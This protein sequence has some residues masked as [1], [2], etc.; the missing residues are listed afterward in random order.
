MME[1]NL[2]YV[3]TKPVMNYVL[4]VLTQFNAGAQ[5]VVIKARGKS[6]TRAVDTAE[7]ITR[8]FLTSAKKKEVTIDTD[9]VE[10]DTGSANVSTIQ[11]ILSWN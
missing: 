3:G 11:I 1:D 4:A 10:T 7:I 9:T 6:I 2:V 8:Q 5:E